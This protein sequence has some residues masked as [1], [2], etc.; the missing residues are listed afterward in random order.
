MSLLQISHNNVLSNKMILFLG[1]Q[2]VT[3][4]YHN[5]SSRILHEVPSKTSLVKRFLRS[6]PT[7]KPFKE[8]KQPK[9]SN[10]Y[11]KGA[12]PIPELSQDLLNNLKKEIEQ[13]KPIAK[14]EEDEVVTDEM[15][16][17]LKKMV[18][19]DKDETIYK[20]ILLDSIWEWEGAKLTVVMCYR[21]F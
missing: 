6:I 18:L 5:W 14:K 12:K 10:L 11:I 1:P 4:G 2:K 9:K 17:A 20:V 13:N 7:R 16:A 19:M 3:L 21:V 8:K 15:R